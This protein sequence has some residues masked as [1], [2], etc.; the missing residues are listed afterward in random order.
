MYVFP[1]RIIAWILLIVAMVLGVVAASTSMWHKEKLGSDVVGPVKGSLVL[2]VGPFRSCAD[3]DVS[4]G[5][6]KNKT[7]VCKNTST[8]LNDA[9]SKDSNR[10]AKLKTVQAMTIVSIVSSGLAVLL[11]G[12]SHAGGNDGEAVRALHNT[13]VFFAWLAGV[14]GAVA[15]S[16]FV[17]IKHM[18]SHLKWGYILMCVSTILSFIGAIMITAPAVP[19][20]DIAPSSPAGETIV[21]AAVAG[22]TNVPVGQVT[23]NHEVGKAALEHENMV[24]AAHDPHSAEGQAAAADHES[25]VH[26]GVAEPKPHPLK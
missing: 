11:C 17:S 15:V 24:K 14:S 5:G 26:A 18:S 16:V 20:K 12:L 19:A 25:E 2:E 21:S 22:A 1:H 3:A 13:S 9:L 6:L 10:N 23:A 8:T 4:V 7:K